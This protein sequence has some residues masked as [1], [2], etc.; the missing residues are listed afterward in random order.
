MKK[1]RTTR[2]M[3]KDTL[4]FT[5]L[6]DKYSDKINKEYA[7][8]INKLISNI[9]KG[10]NLDIKMLKDKYLKTLDEKKIKVIENKDKI[11]NNSEENQDDNTDNHTDNHTDNNTDNHTDNNTDNNTDNH[12][13]NNTDNNTDS[14]N[15]ELNIDTN[16]EEIFF[17][18][19]V[20][21]GINYY[22][23]NKE[24]GRIY[25]SSSKIVGSYKKNKFI[26]N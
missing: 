14:P 23:E 11:L 16:N 7:K 4:L 22:Y 12:T 25:N 19:I 24:D 2:E 13:D 21:D 6:I 3:C 15:I 5:E 20:I 9:A 1:L 8:K 18:K 17:D 10:E 26:F